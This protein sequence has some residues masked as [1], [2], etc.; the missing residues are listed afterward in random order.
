VREDPLE[1]A[2][3]RQ[4]IP[5]FLVVED[6]AA[7]NGRLRQVPDQRLLAQRQRGKAVGIQLH[8]R[9]IVHPLEEVL[10]LAAV[11]GGC[12]RRRR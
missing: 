11:R 6:V 4:R 9:C 1:H 12:R 7:G 5:V 2:P 3:H 10:A 8:D